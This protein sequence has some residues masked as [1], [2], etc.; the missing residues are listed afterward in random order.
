[1]D[2]LADFFKVFFKDIQEYFYDLFVGLFLDIFSFFNSIIDKVTG[3]LPDLSGLDVWS[4]IPESLL[5]IFELVGLGT[6]F[7]MIAGAIGIRFVM[8][9]LPFVR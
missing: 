4:G 5:Q 6:A 7:E 1:M 9:I 3:L 2:N 8:N